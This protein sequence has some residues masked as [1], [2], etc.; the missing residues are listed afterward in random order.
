MVAAVSSAATFHLGSWIVETSERGGWSVARDGASPMPSAAAPLWDAVSLLKIG[1]VDLAALKESGQLHIAGADRTADDNGPKGVRMGEAGV[2]YAGARQDGMR[3]TLAFTSSVWRVE[4]R[5]EFADRPVR[6][7]RSLGILNVSDRRRAFREVK[8]RFP[9]KPE[10]TYYLPATFW[11]YQNELPDAE[12]PTWGKCFAPPSAQG[13]MKWVKAGT[14]LRSHYRA[15]GLV[16]APQAGKSILFFLDPTMDNGTPQFAR[17]DD[18]FVYESSMSA[19][20]WAEPG[21]P[22]T[23]G[24]DV[25]EFTDLDPMRALHERFPKLLRDRGVVPP[26]DRPAWVPDASLYCFEAL[27]C[28]GGA[29]VGGFKAAESV[30]IR[31]R[32]LG[33][34]ATWCLPVQTGNVGYTPDDFYKMNPRL[35]TEA[36]YRDM[37]GAFHANGIRFL[38]DIVPH[39]GYWRSWQR[40]TTGV[41]SAVFTPDGNVLSFWGM[42][43][44]DPG[45]RR[46]MADV[47]GFYR[48]LGVDGFRIDAPYGS[49]KPN[50]RNPDMVRLPTVV[51]HI[52]ASKPQSAYDAAA[53]S[54]A[55]AKCGGRLPPLAYPRASMAQCWGGC[56]MVDSIRAAAR[57][58]N[59]DGAVI[60]EV[61]GLPFTGCSDMLFDMTFPYL[62]YRL[63]N[64]DPGTFVSGYSRWMDER[65]CITPADAVMLR[66]TACHDQLYQTYFLGAAAWRAMIASA[67]LVRGVPL[68]FD[69][70]ET[71]SGVFIRNLNRLRAARAELRR[72]DA[73]YIG[74]KPDRDCVFAVKRTLGDSSGVG[75]INF[76]ADEVTTSLK[77]APGLGARRL[78]PWEFVYIDARTGEEARPSVFRSYPSAVDA[79]VESGIAKDG[80]RVLDL[81]RFTRWRVRTLD[82]GL[83]DFIDPKAVALRLYG[84]RRSGGGAW[85][86]W[87]GATL[88]DS[89]RQP[90]DP[91]EPTIE[92]AND[93]GEA[94]YFRAEDYPS[95][96]FSILAKDGNEAGLKLV[97]TPDA[98][99]SVRYETS[100][101]PIPAKPSA[102]GL[103][104]LRGESLAYR[105]TNGKYDIRLRRLGGGIRSWK[106]AAGVEL[107]E[108]NDVVARTPSGATYGVGGWDL[109]TELKVRREDRTLV[110]SFYSYLRQPGNKRCREIES[111]LEYRFDESAAVK[112][113]SL[114]RPL[115]P[116]ADHSVSWIA[117]LTK[118]GRARMRASGGIGFRK[119]EW[120]L[121]LTHGAK[122]LLPW[123]DHANDFV[124]ADGETPPKPT[125]AAPFDPKPFGTDLSFAARTG[126][127]DE[128]GRRHF[129]PPPGLAGGV[130]W[131]ERFF[132]WFVEDA[133]ADCGVAFKVKMPDPTFE[134]F[135]AKEAEP[136]RC[137][138]AVRVR[139]ERVRR[140]RGP[141]SGDYIDCGYG[142]N[143]PVSVTLSGWRGDGSRWFATKAYSLPED[144]P[145]TDLE[146][147]PVIPE[148]LYGVKV[149]VSVRAELEAEVF[150][151]GLR[152]GRREPKSYHVDSVNGNDGADG[153]TPQTAWRTIE[154]ANAADLKPGDR[155]LFRRGGL[156]RGSLRARS[157][158]PGMP[159][160]YGAYGE[161][162]LPILQRSVD[163]SAHGDWQEVEPGVW[164]TAD[165]RA[166]REGQVVDL[167]ALTNRWD[168]NGGAKSSIR[169]LDED[170]RA[171]LRLAVDRPTKNVSEV[172]LWG[173]ALPKADGDMEFVFELRASREMFVPDCKF[174]T[175][176]GQPFVSTH[177]GE[178]EIR[179]VSN[180]WTRVALPMVC[181]G[182]DRRAVHPHFQFGG[183]LKQGVTLDFR[184]VGIWRTRLLAQALHYDVGNLILGHGKAWGVKKWRREALKEDLDYWYDPSGKRVFVRSEGNPA[185]RFGSVELALT[186]HIIVE[187]DCHDVTYEN[188]MLRYTGA[189]GW[190]GGNTSNITIRCCEAHVIGGG[191]QLW[192]RLPSGICYP[193]RYGNAVEF[194]GHAVGNLV[195]RNRFSEVYDAAV[196]SQTNGEPRPE[197]DIVWRDNVI[198]NAEFSFEFWNQDPRSWT[199]N[200]LFEHNTCVDAGGCW[201]HAQRPDKRGTH[202]MFYPTRGAVTNFVVRNNI[203][204][205]TTDR[206]CLMFNDWRMKNPAARDG[207]V[208][209]NNLYWIPSGKVYEL[210]SPE[211]T[212]DKPHL[213][214][215]AGEGEFKRYQAES[216]LDAHSVY[217]EPQFMDE[218]KRDYRL[219]PGY[220]GRTLATDGGPMGARD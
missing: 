109:D 197:R 138:L 211:F 26:A 38:Q 87:A 136:G 76:S 110:L 23:V 18:A 144:F 188:L 174:T 150:I 153:L 180:V 134:Q 120:T 39:G 127:T 73:D 65:Q 195:E 66:Y 42:D 103:P 15:K 3:L 181:R 198:W 175:Y 85:R 151:G 124:L 62:T 191:L 184:P 205:R 155:L 164:A 52:T 132:G 159:V 70:D 177:R 25:Y 60:S 97:I 189:H 36:E 7:R 93:A 206:S 140:Y 48:S 202:L 172:Q 119:D 29:C 203:F 126:F 200:I 53:W 129:A 112:V 81:K 193:V 86:T 44:A 122:R 56:R 80:T 84:T 208:L 35:G 21:V 133:G 27:G 173:P 82:G 45:W 118:E 217:D 137:P 28:R 33:F 43:F 161:G 77:G 141:R 96:T 30:A 165:A 106:D 216:G 116:L 139:G 207:L 176:S 16:A 135:V 157:G 31:A 32:E 130:R 123:C 219:K 68:V 94:F 49:F 149:E 46:Y 145:W 22:Q 214:F 37:V 146:F 152:Y 179:S 171:F 185:E 11:G 90:L 14:V 75:L 78:G 169:K 143:P 111:A 220:R 54:N 63:L 163:R 58:G 64:L 210:N 71:G 83:N 166:V 24:N 194:W 41:E 101:A 212:K 99:K 5:L 95:A 107:F 2:A 192:K 125:F 187:T 201:S 1:G 156:W 204:C 209:D 113:R 88:W 158:T 170:G 34:N 4:E 147:E 92:F 121:D 162:P 196:T 102:A 148:N 20:G 51:D 108:G 218:S 183:F 12:I 50:W 6:I 61:F 17:T 10:G 182:T 100:S 160:Y 8:L 105:V 190:C 131:G 213:V 178:P 199:G 40:R 19:Q 98:G 167:G 69:P 117:K 104:V 154:K 115:A 91:T 114:V 79:R 215:G 59:P 128:T 47:A 168:F 57:K 9:M 55:L 186:E 142:E 13:D 72:G 67:F 74:L 89:E